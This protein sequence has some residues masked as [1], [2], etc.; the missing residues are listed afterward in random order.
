M[1]RVLV[2]NLA[3]VISTLLHYNY[4]VCRNIDIVTYRIQIDN[5]NGKVR[6]GSISQKN[7]STLTKV[8][9]KRV[10]FIYLFRAHTI[11]GL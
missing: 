2:Q 5:R 10:L 7:S 1:I 11:L 6:E 3:S 4:I 9:A 8:L